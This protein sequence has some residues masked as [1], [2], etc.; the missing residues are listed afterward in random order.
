ML[1][2][3]LSQVT[4][5]FFALEKGENIKGGFINFSPATAPS[6]DVPGN[7][8]SLKKAENSRFQHFQP[9]MVV[10]ERGTLMGKKALD[11]SYIFDL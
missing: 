6:P 8:R 10:W 4:G 11:R 2:S 7:S 3:R 9:L 1:K 5:G